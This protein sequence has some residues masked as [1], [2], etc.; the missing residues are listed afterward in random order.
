MSQSPYAEEIAEIWA[1]F[2][3]T[4]ARFK[5]TDARLDQRFKETDAR[6]DQRF[7]ETDDKL[8]RLEGMFGIQWGRMLEALVRPAALKLFQERG[9]DVHYTYQRLQSSVNGRHMELDVVLENDEDVV[10]IEV[11]SLVRVE[12]VDDLVEDLQEIVTF[13]TKY[14]GRRIYGGLAGLEFAEGADR[15]AYRRGL[16]VLRLN[17]DGLVQIQNDPQFTPRD[18]GL[19]RT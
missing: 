4:D 8:R 14:G 9:I 15:Y 12:D 5:E 7:K 16:F 2:R 18:F 19:A 6:L 3:E 13:F 17:G 11:K 1:L 10:V